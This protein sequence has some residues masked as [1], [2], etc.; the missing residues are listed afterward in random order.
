MTKSIDNHTYTS[1][2][3]NMRSHKQESGPRHLV[4]IDIENMAGTPSPTALDV[5]QVKAA[6]RTAIPDLEQAQCVV[7]CSHRAAAVV[8]FGFPAALRRWRSGIDGADRA[9]MGELSDLRVMKRFGKVTICSGDGIFTESIAAIA[10]LGVET[11]VVSLQ[12]H[13]SK[14][15]KCAARSV[16]LVAL[17]DTPP[18]VSA[19]KGAA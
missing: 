7:A 11:T 3:V 4:L 10:E 14:R 2:L 15:L 13:L 9:L 17:G 1:I 12:G 18:P 6:L 8:S 5:D 16:V 19:L